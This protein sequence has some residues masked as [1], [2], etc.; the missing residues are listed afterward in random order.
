MDEEVQHRLTGRSGTSYKG[1]AVS[2]SRLDVL[3][4]LHHGMSRGREKA[5]LLNQKTNYQEMT[6]PVKRR[7]DSKTMPERCL[8][9][10]VSHFIERRV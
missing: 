8:F 10:R 7:A 1:R 2:Q 6:F 4:A 3:G 9:T 5:V